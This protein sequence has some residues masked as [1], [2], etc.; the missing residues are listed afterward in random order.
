MEKGAIFGIILR[1]GF[2]PTNK[3]TMNVTMTNVRLKELPDYLYLTVGNVSQQHTFIYEYKIPWRSKEEKFEDY[4]EKA[5]FDPEIF[6]NILLPPIIFNAGYSMKKV[7]SL[8]L[9]Q[10][11]FFL[12]FELNCHFQLFCLFSETFFQEFRC[13]SSICSNRNSYFMLCYWVKTIISTLLRVK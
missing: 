11:V 1:Y 4:E 6:F 12:T 7:N 13:Y 10:L 3:K 9:C 8:V 2:K 5:S